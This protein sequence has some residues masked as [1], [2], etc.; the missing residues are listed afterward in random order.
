MTDET[1]K[2]ETPTVDRA[3]A[4]ADPAVVYVCG[5]CQDTGFIHGI[6]AVMHCGSGQA[7]HCDCPTCK[8]PIAVVAKNP[9][10]QGEQRSVLLPH[11]VGMNRQQRRAEDARRNGKLGRPLGV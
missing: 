10:A 3:A 6:R 4:F 9:H 2:P 11:E 7:I 8:K 1:S 5:H